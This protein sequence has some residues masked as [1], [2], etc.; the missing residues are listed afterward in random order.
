MEKNDTKI[1]YM[2]TNELFKHIK[3][4]NKDTPKRSM[5]KLSIRTHSH[6]RTRSDE[7]KLDSFKFRKGL[8]KKRFTNRVVDERNKLSG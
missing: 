1:P 8:S 6:M 7:R 3:R 4:S 2:G 5:S